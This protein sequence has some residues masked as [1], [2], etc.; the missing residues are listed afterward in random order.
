MIKIVILKK[1]NIG[2]VDD[3]NLDHGR[4][5]HGTFLPLTA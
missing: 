3:S 4:D 1:M 5:A 2:A